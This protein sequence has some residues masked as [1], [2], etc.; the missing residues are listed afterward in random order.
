MEMACSGLQMR[1]AGYRI[2][3]FSFSVFQE[4]L[5][6]PCSFVRA[7]RRMWLHQRRQRECGHRYRYGRQGVAHRSCST[8]TTKT[9][10]FATH[11][12]RRLTNGFTCRC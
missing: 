10:F 6:F 1:C 3:S 7:I 9:G 4:T 11:A 2:S 8:V 12:R 5:C